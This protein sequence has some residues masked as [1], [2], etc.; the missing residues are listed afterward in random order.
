[1]SLDTWMFIIVLMLIGIGYELR[2]MNETR[3]EAE[4]AV[5]GFSC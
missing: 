3:E 4:R 5:E 2:K 1:M